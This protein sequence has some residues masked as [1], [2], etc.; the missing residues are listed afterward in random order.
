MRIAVALADGH[1]STGDYER[2]YKVLKKSIELVMPDVPVDLIRFT[3][4]ERGKNHTPSLQANHAKMLAWAEYIE[5]AD[6]D[7]VFTDA[8]MF[9]NGDL[10]DVFEKY[11]FDVAITY[12]DYSSIPINGGVV[13]V[14]NTDDAK[15]FIKKWA[16]EDTLLYENA[17]E[18][19]KWRKKCHGMN[20]ASLG[21]MMSEQSYPGKLIK[22]ECSKYNACE[23]SWKHFHEH[24]PYMVHCKSNMKRSLM[25]NKKLSSLHIKMRAVAERW[26]E[27]AALVDK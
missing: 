10:R 7:V 18:H 22:I 5:S 9:A 4:L 6:D 24:K 20:Q 13:F 25:D 12:R 3:P 2:M 16:E 17:T 27:L 15:A 21:K 23:D 26:Y 8:D 11:D 19:L 1:V 14:R